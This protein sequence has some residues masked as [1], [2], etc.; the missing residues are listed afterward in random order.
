VPLER[1]KRNY[2]ESSFKQL[3]MELQNAEEARLAQTDPVQH[4]QFHVQRGQELL[5]EG[6]MRQAEKQFREAVTLDSSNAGAHAGLAQV[7][8][9]AEDAA[10]A[11]R[12]AVAS[13][14]LKPS[15]EAYL[16][17]AKLDLAQNNRGEAEKN[18]EQAL[19]L[20]PNNATALEI[21]RDLMTRS[22]ASPK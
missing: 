9:A 12:E 6:L 8:E 21:K 18:V 14:G 1:I 16:V 10:G 20:D 7:L 22:V 5:Q 11:R 17:L 2:D 4:A 19:T 13:L 3:A 15:A